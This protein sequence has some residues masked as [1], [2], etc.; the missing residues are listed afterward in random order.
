MLLQRRIS[1]AFARPWLELPNYAIP[2]ELPPVEANE[3]RR[4]AGDSV[5]FLQVPNL[6]PSLLSLFAFLLRTNTGLSRADA[7]MVATAPLRFVPRKSPD[8]ASLIVQ[9]R[10]LFL[11]IGS[12]VPE[13]IA[14]LERSANIDPEECVKVLVRPMEAI[15]ARG[16]LGVDV[17]Q[18]LIQ[19]L[20]NTHAFVGERLFPAHEATVG[21]S[22]STSRG[23]WGC[24]STR[25]PASSR[26]MP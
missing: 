3:V 18:Q 11:V 17:L 2:E 9:L 21:V 10:A 24:S 19:L 15:F 6:P 8:P 1:D 14:K 7:E 23:S 5:G 4:I 20:K 25:P 12:Q 26:A 22:L 16:R 13:E